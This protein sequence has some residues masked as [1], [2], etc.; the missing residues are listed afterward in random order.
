VSFSRQGDEQPLEN[1]LWERIREREF[2]DTENLFP[3]PFLTLPPLNPHKCNNFCALG[4]KESAQDM[5]KND[6]FAVNFPV[7]REMQPETS[8]SQT[9]STAISS[10]P[11]SFYPKE[12]GNPP[13]CPVFPI[14]LRRLR[15]QRNALPSA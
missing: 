1:L 11:R 2:P 14:S 12:F 10:S 7:R 5:P 3:V 15:P 4:A 13:K 9:A 6:K 8:L